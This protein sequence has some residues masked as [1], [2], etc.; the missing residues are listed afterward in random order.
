MNI[1]PI[2]NTENDY[3]NIGIIINLFCN[4]T[5]YNNFPYILTEIVDSL[6]NENLNIIFVS[7]RLK[8]FLNNNM[9]LCYDSHNLLELFD[10][11]SSV[12]VV[13]KEFIRIFHRLYENSPLFDIYSKGIDEDDEKID[14]VN[15]VYLIYVF[16]IMF[17]F[18]E[19][20]KHNNP[21]GESN[22]GQSDQYYKLDRHTLDLKQRNINITVKSAMR[23]ISDNKE[24][25]NPYFIINWGD[26]IYHTSEIIVKT[27]YPA[28]N[29]S[30]K[31]PI[32]E[33][34]EINLI[35]SNVPIQFILYSK[36]LNQLHSSSSMQNQDEYIGESKIYINDL[37]K[38]LTINNNEH[39]GFYHISSISNIIKGQ[40][41]IK[42]KFDSELTDLIR[43]KMS[44]IDPLASN[45][46]LFLTK[47]FFEGD[48][49]NENFSF[50]TSLKA[51]NNDFLNCNFTSE[52][53]WK[54]LNQNIVIKYLKTG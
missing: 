50:K 54:N 5:F 33:S 16:K 18:Q 10:N 13:L 22:L 19:D 12:K 41:N 9:K 4:S 44:N 3:F 25:L 20:C 27:S 8:K 34:S 15:F 11:K 53:L 7:F 38:M 37:L 52:D 43:N 45:T 46:N 26:Q 39:E 36:N 29:D 6:S 30:F 40:F 2:E 14:L 24:K 28:W 1:L 23:L 35:K 42:F 51:T 17:G 49:K 21:R 48:N 32:N 31:L 47:N